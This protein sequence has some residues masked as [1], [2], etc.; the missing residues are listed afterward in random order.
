MASELDT[1]R[2]I[3]SHG[4]LNPVQAARLQELSRE[5]SMGN[6][7]GVAGNAGQYLDDQYLTQDG[8]INRNTN[9]YMKAIEPAVKSYESSIPETQQRFSTERERL[10]GESSRLEDRYK[11]LIDDIK[12]NQGVAET[13]QTRTT[14]AEMARRGI[15]NSSGVYGQEMTDVLNPITAD[16]TSKI[17]S[18]GLEREDMLARIRDSI[19]GLTGQ[20]TDAIR[21][22]RN[23]IAQLQAGAGQSGIAQGIQ[24]FQQNIQNALAQGQLTIQQANQALAERQ[25]QLAQ[26]QYNQIT[27]PE[28]RLQQQAAQLAFQK[29][30]APAMTPYTSSSLQSNLGAATTPKPTEKPSF[31]KYGMSTVNGPITYRY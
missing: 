5:G 11:L 29:A 23:A 18:T 26:Q 15:T 4:N 21:A 7:Q 24:S 22:V 1:L 17:K 2:D 16:Y 6:P 20:E 27:L 8:L 12:R 28:S 19:T 31:S 30:S 3:S 10:S 25:Q 9:R 13:R 14:N